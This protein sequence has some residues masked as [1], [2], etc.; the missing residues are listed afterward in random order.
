MGRVMRVL[1]M[2]NET[3]SSVVRQVT[4]IF[5]ELSAVGY[6]P[7]ALSQVLRKAEREAWCSLREVWSVLAVDAK[8]A[9]FV[10]ALDDAVGEVER[11]VA[12]RSCA[13]RPA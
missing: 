13:Q 1:D 4:R 11:L 6:T 12:K 7:A 8:T 9:R 3:E 2:T 10:S 5:C